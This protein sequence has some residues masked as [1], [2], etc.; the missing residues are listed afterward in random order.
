[1]CQSP[2]K[3]ATEINVMTHGYLGGKEDYPLTQ[4]EIDTNQIIRFGDQDAERN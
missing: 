2:L 4:E 1:M 3:A